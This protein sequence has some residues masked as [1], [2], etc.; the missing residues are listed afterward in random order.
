MKINCVL[1]A[2]NTNP[3]YMEFIPIFIKTWNKLFPNVDIKIIFLSNEIPDELKYYEKYLILHPIEDFN[4]PKEAEP[5]VTV[6]I[7]YLYPVILDCSGGVMITDIDMIPMN[8]RYYTETIEYISNDKYINTRD[9]NDGYQFA[10]CYNIALPK[11]WGEIWNVKNFNDIKQKLHNVWNKELDTIPEK[12]VKQSSYKGWFK[13]QI[14]GLKNIKKWNEKTGNYIVL[15][16]KYTK[17]RRLDRGRKRGINLNVEK[18]NIKN[19]VYSD[20]HMCRPY[21]K[22]KKLNDEIYDLL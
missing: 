12:L 11:I 20:Y 4:L 5:F 22:Y 13:D 19:G 1:T 14:D 8:R 15:K 6:Y 16:D 9:W 7:R 10:S 17:F 21:S 2:C 18:D 3:M